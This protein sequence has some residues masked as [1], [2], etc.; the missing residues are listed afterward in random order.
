MHINLDSDIRLD[1]CTH[2]N[3][4]VL[5]SNK[6]ANERFIF[7]TGHNNKLNNNIYFNNLFTRTALSGM[8]GMY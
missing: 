8:T 4:M 2:I 3:I 6:Q 7:N 1:G 5:D